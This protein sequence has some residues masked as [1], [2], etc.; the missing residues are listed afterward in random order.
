M[1]KLRLVAK[2]REPGFISFQMGE[3]KAGGEVNI[4]IRTRG[5]TL[6]EI[7]QEVSLRQVARLVKLLE[8]GRG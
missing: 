7:S 6:L 8:Q 1:G 3:A 5:G 4:T 2:N